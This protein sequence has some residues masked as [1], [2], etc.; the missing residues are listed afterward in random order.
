MAARLSVDGRWR[1]QI[2]YGL[3]QQVNKAGGD[4]EWDEG[5]ASCSDGRSLGAP[6]RRGERPELSGKSIS[7]VV[8]FGPGSGSDIIA[9]IIGQRLGV[10]LSQSAIRPSS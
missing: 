4:G 9:R 1:R 6:R 3:A 7:F 8:P 5:P 2:C 10:V